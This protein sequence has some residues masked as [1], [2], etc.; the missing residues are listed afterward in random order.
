MG[1]ITTIK[2]ARVLVRNRVKLGFDSTGEGIAFFCT[3]IPPLNLILALLCKIIAHTQSKWLFD[4]YYWLLGCGFGFGALRNLDPESKK[5]IQAWIQDK[6]NESLIELFIQK[7]IPEISAIVDSLKDQGYAKLPWVFSEEEVKAFLSYCAQQSYFA[8]QTPLQSDY[9]LKKGFLEFI[10]DERV[11]ADKRYRCLI[12]F[13]GSDL[14]FIKKFIESPLVRG[15]CASYLRE[16]PS[17]Y[18]SN[19]FLSRPG[20]G[21]HY[22]MRTHRDYDGFNTLTFFIGWTA[23][24]QDDGAT[25]FVPESHRTSKVQNSHVVS[26][27]CAPGE[28]YVV[29]TFGLHSGNSNIKKPRLASWIRFG[30]LP[31]LAYTQDAPRRVI[32][33]MNNAG[34][35]AA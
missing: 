14:G 34:R 29:D 1:I 25:L 13:A 12:P 5:A 3:L 18:S 8:S 22:V 28:V 30:S 26:L 11:A 10:P 17:M 33:D 16:V 21:S 6:H 20:L 7:A 24:A 35:K 4:V 15:I 19:T 27:D 31:N 32:N 2:T 23:T 9:I